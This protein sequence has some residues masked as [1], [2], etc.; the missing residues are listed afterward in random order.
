MWLTVMWVVS[1]VWLFAVTQFPLN[2]GMIGLESIGCMTM[3]WTMLMYR[4]A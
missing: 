3:I 1:S 4:D 2:F